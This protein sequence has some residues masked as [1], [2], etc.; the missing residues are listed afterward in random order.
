MHIDDGNA[1]DEDEQWRYLLFAAPGSADVIA[2]D[3]VT[4]I[5]I[6]IY[7]DIGYGFAIA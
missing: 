3:N 6:G 7:I 5:G 4:G 1:T 2:I